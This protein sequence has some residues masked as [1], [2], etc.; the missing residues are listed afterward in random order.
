[1]K[2]YPKLPIGTKIRFQVEPESPSYPGYPHTF[3]GVILTNAGYSNPD[4]GY[5][6]IF[7][8]ETRKK[9]PKVTTDWWVSPDGILDNPYYSYDRAMQGI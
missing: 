1:M 3:S 2:K 8:D 6:V 7:D 5:Y 4:P 9:Y